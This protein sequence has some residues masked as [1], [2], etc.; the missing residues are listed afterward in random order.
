MNRSEWEKEVERLATT[1]G[2]WPKRITTEVKHDQQLRREHFLAGFETSWVWDATIYRADG[3]YICGEGPTPEHSLAALK[4]A[5]VNAVGTN[6]TDA[7]QREAA[8]N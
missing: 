5:I 4:A 3:G 7:E 1:S 6:A 8:S 2:L